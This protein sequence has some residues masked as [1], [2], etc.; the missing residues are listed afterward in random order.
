[1]IVHSLYNIN[2][3]DEKILDKGGQYGGKGYK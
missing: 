3:S 1:M 2:V